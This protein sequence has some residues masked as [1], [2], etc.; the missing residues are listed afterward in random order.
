MKAAKTLTPLD[1]Y[2]FLLNVA[3]VRPVMIWGPPG[4]GKSAIVAQFADAVGMTCVSLLGSNLA[5]EDIIGVPKIDGEVSR[6]FP[7][8]LIVHPEPFVLFI[9]EINACSQEVQK[10]FYS[11]IHEKRIGEYQLPAGSIVIAAGNRAEDSAIV[12]PMSS[13]LINRMAHVAL[14]PDPRAWLQWATRPEVSIHPLV[15]DYICTRG[16]HLWSKPPKTEAP[17][18]TPR[19]WE[20]LSDCLKNWDPAEL[21]GPEG[22]EIVSSLAHGLVSPEH[23]GTFTAFVRLRHRMHDLEA[24]IAGKQTWPAHETEREMLIFLAESFRAKLI[25]ELPEDRSKLG[26]EARALTLRTK[27]L[28]VQLSRISQEIAQLILTRDHN[29]NTIPNWLTIEIARDLPRLA[30]SSQTQGA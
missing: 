19:S 21:E 27:D 7:P 3:V 10:A 16:D 24:I 22:G 11:L 1:L 18:S 25:K 8:S 5:P 23:A 26:G 17:F 29:G 30:G 6:F 9:D 14:E 12:K 28:L 20:Y 2:R 13:A 15:H 4:I